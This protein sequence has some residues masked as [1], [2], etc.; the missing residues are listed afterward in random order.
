[1]YSDIIYAM[2]EEEMMRKEGEAF[3]AAHQA[4]GSCSHHHS[5]HTTDQD[6]V[7]EIYTYDNAQ[8]YMFVHWYYFRK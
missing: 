4:P 5:H 6:W 1:M 3:Y 8:F 2:A 7:G